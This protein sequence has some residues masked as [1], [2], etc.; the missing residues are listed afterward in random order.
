MLLKALTDGSVAG[1]G[2]LTFPSNFQGGIL[3]GVLITT[4]G[5][6]AAVVTVQRTDSSGKTIFKI[7]TKQP[8]M[9]MAPFGM[10]G[11]TVAYYSVS[12]TGAA[13]QFFEWCE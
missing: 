3:G 9:I 13:A 4:D 12:G 7:S 2:T 1:T 5:T 8:L 6:N 10:E 11:A